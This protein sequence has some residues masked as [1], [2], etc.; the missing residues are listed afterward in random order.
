MSCAYQSS[1]VGL[2]SRPATSSLRKATRHQLSW[3][4]H[5]IS[6]RNAFYSRFYAI[7]TGNLQQR[8]PPAHVSEAC[9][10]GALGLPSQ[11]A[12]VRRLSTS[13][14]YSKRLPRGSHPTRPQRESPTQV[15]IPFDEFTQSQ[16]KTIF[17]HDVEPSE[18]NL[19]LRTLH[20]R[21][22]EGSLIDYGTHIAGTKELPQDASERALKWLREKHPLN[23]QAAADVWL[24]RELSK[25]EKTY[26]D[27][28]EK[29][30]LYKR[31]EADE[32]QAIPER[33]TSDT[34][35][36]VLEQ[37]KNYHTKRREREAKE[38]E[39]RQ[40]TPEYKAQEEVRLARV[41]ERKTELAELREQ[42]AE[43]KAYLAEQGK[44]SDFTEPP[45]MSH[46]QRLGPATLFGLLVL[47]GC[48]WYAENYEPPSQDQ[49]L[50]PRVPVS[51]ATV[52]G[53][54]MFNVTITS[55]ARFP[56]FHRIMNKYFL[57]VPAYP[58]AFSILGNI[59][60]H[61]HWRHLGSNMVTLTLYGVSL[62]EELGRGQFMALY[63][64]GG[65]MG[66]LFSLWYFVLT[67]TLGTS[68]CGASGCAWAVVAAWAYMT[69]SNPPRSTEN[70]DFAFDVLR[71]MVV[72]LQVLNHFKA[73]VL[74]TVD[75]IAH[76]AG[77]ASGL[78]IAWSLRHG[79]MPPR[80]TA[81]QLAQ[82]AALAQA[83]REE[84]EQIE[85]EKERAVADAKQHDADA[86]AK[87]LRARASSWFSRS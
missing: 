65:I 35:H 54:I 9:V 25:L 32:E 56:I 41:E 52:G 34:S 58:Y 33:S 47:A 80:P 11:S 30:G 75:V 37:F 67:R 57:Q 51:V 19:I 5:S 45:E 26:I 6:K 83:R 39:A 12:S 63:V 20:Q 23:E 22:A 77:A 86:A 78:T 74:E 2:I 27:R 3:T 72:V 21:R 18:G 14:A 17:Q 42:L 44:V 59:V 66:S 15:K 8:N 38:E 71:Y 31:V 50:Y 68:H 76:A 87:S 84:E 69:A 16:L 40:A 81:Q 53:I 13:P 48:Y 43:R 36:S 1:L 28:A 79:S 29:L 60:H 55:L 61:V 4:R 49:R 62:H 73:N 64:S 24:N 85:K 70:Y 46:L 82:E 7:A 10:S